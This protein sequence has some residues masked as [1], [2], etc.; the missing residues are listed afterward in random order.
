[1]T[2]ILFY[3]GHPAQYLFLRESIRQLKKKNIEIIV[4]IK[5][6]DVLEQL[7]IN[8]KLPY[9][10][11]LPIKRGN[12]KFLIFLSLIKRIIKLFPVIQKNKPDLLIGT[13]S[14]IAII[15]AMLSIKCI[16]ILED[17]YD[18]IKTMAMITNPF[19][20]IILS[21]EVCD[22]GP[23]KQKKIG[24]K[25]YM[26][27]GYLHPG[28][29]HADKKVVAKYEIPQNFVL[30]RLARLTAHHDFG[31]SGINEQLLDKIL[32]ICASHGTVV[33]I[34]SEAGLDEKYQKHELSIN[35]SDIHHILANASL[36]I[37]DSQSM[38]V[39]SAMLGVPSIRYSDFAGRISVLEEL[40]HK[41]HLTFG[42]NT[43]QP[44]ML[45]SKTD[46]LLS[47]NDVKSEFQ[48][49]RQL[50]LND[51]IDVSSFMVWFLSNFPVSFTIMKEN[52]DYQ[53]KFR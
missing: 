17:D 42:I 53:W 4:A 29:F 7:L 30:I 19:T 16:T 46:E 50:M 20:T 32:E 28:V 34:S 23:W 18:V 22:V 11:V 2:K 15:G 24:Y 12:S 14:S 36:L 51:K 13:D 45:F 27:L 9:I 31:I 6:K 37:C 5:S 1:M 44:E 26:K 8:D 10:N 49:R 39:E 43:C 38:S 21:P 35:P 33:R 3:F 52:P 47:M 48:R 41:Y 40:E 25:G